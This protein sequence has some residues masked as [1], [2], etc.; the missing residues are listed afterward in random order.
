MD[1][2]G[3]IYFFF[4]EF[5]HFLWSRNF[6]FLLRRHFLKP[7]LW[8]FLQHNLSFFR[9]R[10]MLFLVNMASTKNKKC[11]HSPS[12]TYSVLGW[13]WNYCFHSSFI[14]H[15]A[16]TNVRKVAFPMLYI[17]YVKVTRRASHVKLIKDAL[18]NC[19]IRNFMRFKAAKRS[20]N[21]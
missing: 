13:S 21:H 8:W 20:V 6:S 19:D 4:P 3:F 15:A 1:Y 7:G 14:R 10:K 16:L 17:P 9:T 12:Q 18:T 11:E 5:S 2:N